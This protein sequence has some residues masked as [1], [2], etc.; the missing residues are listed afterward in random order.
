MG[1]FLIQLWGNMSTGKISLTGGISEKAH[2]GSQKPTHC[3]LLPELVLFYVVAP[4]DHRCIQTI[5]TLNVKM[6]NWRICWRTKNK[7]T[8]KLENP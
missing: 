3:F 7:K 2:L 8:N 6:L 4:L 1:F 5:L